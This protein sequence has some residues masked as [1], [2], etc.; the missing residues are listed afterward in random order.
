ME[1]LLNNIINHHLNLNAKFFLPQD[2]ND[3]E[4]WIRDNLL[5]DYYQGDFVDIAM[6]S[7]QKLYLCKSETAIMGVYNNLICSLNKLEWGVSA[8]NEV[9][10]M[11][12]RYA[13]NGEKLYK[14]HYKQF[15]EKQLNF[16][17]K[18]KENHIGFYENSKEQ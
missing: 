14:L 7:I 11:V 5:D 8:Y 10:D 6:E 18:I 17:N 4:N 1:S 12:S 15:S 2:K 3:I 9:V 16:Y 13:K